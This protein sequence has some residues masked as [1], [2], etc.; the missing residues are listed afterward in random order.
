[1]ATKK[2]HVPNYGLHTTAAGVTYLHQGRNAFNFIGLQEVSPFQI[3]NKHRACPHLVHHAAPFPD[4]HHWR[5]FM[6][7][8][9]DPLVQELLPIPK[10]NGALIPFLPDAKN[11]LAMA[12]VVLSRMS[13][14][15]YQLV[16]PLSKFTKQKLL[17]E[18]DITN[19]APLIITGVQPSD[20]DLLYEI[21]SE[22]QKLPRKLL[23]SGDPALVIDAPLK[24]LATSILLADDLRIASLPMEAL[25]SF[26]L[27]RHA[28]NE[29]LDADIEK[30]VE[31]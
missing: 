13:S 9:Y 28:R 1:M 11:E 25:G 19:T 4:K 31:R 16:H 23:F 3:S 18:L 5:T 24:R 21:A 29:K 8:F 30:K 15:I 20:Q 26:L 6:R 22:A 10:Q 7:I 12:L 17:A 27:R 2:I 14:P